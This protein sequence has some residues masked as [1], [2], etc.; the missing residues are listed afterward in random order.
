MKC[1]INLL[2]LVLIVAYF[3]CTKIFKNCI[4]FI[5]NQWNHG[6][7]PKEILKKKWAYFLMFM[8]KKCHIKNL[9]LGRRIFWPILP[10]L[11]PHVIG[12]KHK[13]FI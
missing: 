13:E 12:E 3:Y 5:K 6:G 8:F 1:N 2:V 7:L 4:Q 10:C 11:D 9:D